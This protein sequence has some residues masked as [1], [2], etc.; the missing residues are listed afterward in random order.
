MKHVNVFKGNM[1]NVKFFA[2]PIQ[3]DNLSIL[4]FYFELKTNNL[5][6]VLKII[7]YDGK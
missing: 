2:L 6:T 7:P 5:S 1:K 4:C 3:A